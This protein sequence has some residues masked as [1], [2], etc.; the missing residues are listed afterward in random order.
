MDQNLVKKVFSDGEFVEALAQME[1]A[2]EVQTALKGKGLEFS[3]DE[4]NDVMSKLKAAQETEL[5]DEQLD[6]VA[7]GAVFVVI[8][9]IAKTVIGSVAKGVTG[10][11]AAGVVTRN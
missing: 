11:V 5:L 8:A 2:K 6:N 1:T 3:M 7:G 10:G 4:I 9:P